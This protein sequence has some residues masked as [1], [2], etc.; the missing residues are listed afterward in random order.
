MDARI[1]GFTKFVANKRESIKR[2]EAVVEGR[3]QAYSDMEQY[4]ANT[5]AQC[6]LTAWSTERLQEHITKE[7]HT[8][9]GTD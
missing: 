6:G 4:W 7:G 2:E 5:C 8:A 9:V 1:D 3:K